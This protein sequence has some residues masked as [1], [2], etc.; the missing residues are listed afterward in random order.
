MKKKN[1]LNAFKALPASILNYL[2]NEIARGSTIVMVSTLDS[3]SV[4][5]GVRAG[6]GR[7]SVLF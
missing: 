1:V 3:G 2:E 4:G 5:K 6:P 7:V